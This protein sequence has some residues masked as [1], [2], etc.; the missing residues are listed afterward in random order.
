M[1]K[2]VDCQMEARTG[3]AIALLLVGCTQP[4][5]LDGIS[6]PTVSVSPPI[7]PKPF[8]RQE[9]PRRLK[10]LLTLDQ[11]DD[12]KVKIKDQ[13]D[14][15]QVLSCRTSI[16]ERLIHER[17]VLLAT[18][19]QFKRQQQTK[20]NN[21]A[22]EVK[23]ANVEITQARQAITYY[24]SRSPYTDL[25][26]RILGKSYIDTTLLKLEQQLYI[27]QN[28]LI[29]ANGKLQSARHQKSD[30][31]SA[32]LSKAQIQEAHLKRL[33]VVRSPYSGMVHSIRWLGQKDQELQAEVTLSILAP[34]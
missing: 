11:P 32:L 5:K 26:Q 16:Q 13:I 15:G 4:Q 18:L 1:F 34:S 28:K 10:I 8:Q 23:A 20:Q 30:D 21:T 14:K 33:G 6:H 31:I 3:I 24:K 2:K 29:I 12:L 17:Q 19:D 25:G 7:A 9:S 22:A 27:A